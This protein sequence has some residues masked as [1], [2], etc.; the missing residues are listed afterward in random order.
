MPKKILICI[1]ALM[2]I[3]TTVLADSFEMNN[4]T[5]YDAY[6]Y[7]EMVDCYSYYK[8]PGKNFAPNETHFSNTS[9][10]VYIVY[11][12][13]NFGTGCAS[14]IKLNY[15]TYG[16]YEGVLEFRKNSADGELLASFE[17]QN[18]HFWYS[19]EKRTQKIIN[20]MSATGR[21]DLYVVI[22]KSTF[23]NLYGFQFIREQSAYEPINAYSALD[24]SCGI[25]EECIGEDGIEFNADNPLLLGDDSSR[26]VEYYM[27]FENKNASELFVE[28]NVEIGGRMRIYNDCASGELLFQ[29]VVASGDG[30]QGF[31]VGEKISELKNTQNLCIVF[32]NSV[33][34]TFKSFY[35]V[36]DGEVKTVDDTIFDATN[37]DGINL[38]K[39]NGSHFG[40]MDL[41]GAWVKW[42]NVDF[43][44]DIWPRV[45]EVSYGLGEGYSGSLLNIRT[46][47]PDGE[48]IASVHLDSRE[49]ISWTNP[50]TANAPML[51]GVTGVHDVYITV[52]AGEFLTKW[53]A[54]NI[55]GIKFDTVNKKYFISYTVDGYIN[56]PQKISSILTFLN[57]DDNPDE[58]VFIF[59]AYDKNG[60]LIAYDFSAEELYEGLNSFEKSL[61]YKT[62]EKSAYTVRAFVWDGENTPLLKDSVLVN[63]SD[64]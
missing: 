13:M 6:A 21:F 51:K 35:F 20:P 62:G 2:F 63:I 52:D 56:D 27:N 4:Q 11:K 9:D 28:A 12:N 53:K 39:D 54:G 49:G 40:Q 59:A 48:I 64:N 19:P 24:R 17:S 10:G 57:D 3:N 31:K 29:T 23:G 43:G 55:F 61:A 1:I 41:T 33:R 34:L 5:N 16:D 60:E 44:E 7:T 32:E 47:S 26:S 22:R 8:S 36:S 18:N 38:A 46:D 25:P 58:I 37:Y 15:S 14:H 42:E 30:K 45:V 50:K